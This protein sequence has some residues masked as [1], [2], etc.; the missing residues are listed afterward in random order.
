MVSLLL[1]WGSLFHSSMIHLPQPLFGIITVLTPVR[2]LVSCGKFP[3]LMKISLVLGNCLLFLWIS[4]LNLGGNS[5]G[6][7]L[8][9][10]IFGKLACCK[11]K[12]SSFAH[13][14][15]VRSLW[16]ISPTLLLGVC[17]PLGANVAHALGSNV[18]HHWGECRPFGVNFA[19]GGGVVL[20]WCPLL[21]MGVVVR[22]SS[23]L[24]FGVGGGP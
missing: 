8:H 16:H 7:G 21:L 13:F 9:P 18:T 4:S 24:A 15:T 1:W 19:C 22:A 2:A 6:L 5:V 17:R 3:Q 11:F 10:R 23:G 12:W 20:P 14:C